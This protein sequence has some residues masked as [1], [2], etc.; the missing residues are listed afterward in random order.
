MTG[1]PA[2]RIARVGMAH[3]CPKGRGIFSNLTV[4]ENLV[5]AFRQRLG[6]KKAGERVGPGL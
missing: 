1:D 2:Y 3:M 6:R 5:L 4:E